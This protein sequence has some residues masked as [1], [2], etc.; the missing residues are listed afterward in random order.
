MAYNWIRETPNNFNNFYKFNKWPSGRKIQI[1]VY[2]CRNSSISLHENNTR[3][4]PIY[5]LLRL[6]Y[7][8]IEGKI[9]EINY[10]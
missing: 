6:K 3:Y 1:K 9:H 7:V 8:V 5:G 4:K 2:V 10:V